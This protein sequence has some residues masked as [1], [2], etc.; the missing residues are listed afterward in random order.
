MAE[1]TGND[2]RKQRERLSPVQN[3]H[4]AVTKKLIPCA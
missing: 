1:S 3:R 2:G 4:E